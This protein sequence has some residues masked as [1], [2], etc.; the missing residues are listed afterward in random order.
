M[1]RQLLTLIAGA[2][3]ITGQTVPQP[4]ADGKY[5][6]S[7]SNIKAQTHPLYLLFSGHYLQ[8]DQGALPLGKILIGSVG[9]INDF[10]ST[11]DMQLGHATGQLGFEGHCGADGA[12]E[13]YNSYWLV[14]NVP[15]NA[16]VARLT[17]PF[18]GVKA[19]LRTDQPGVVV[20]LC[21]WFNGTAAPKRTQGL[22]DRRNV[23]RSPW[24]ALEA[25]G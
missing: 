3:L 5:T 25:Q 22:S 6:I 16:V 15:C 20:Y 12:C 14:E 18:S 2:V 19:E 17:S 23:T 1:G 7:T 13:G 21:N 11:P 9:N 24:A 10:A 8:A 4:G